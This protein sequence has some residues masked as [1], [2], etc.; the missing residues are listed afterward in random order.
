MNAFF[1]IN[2]LRRFLVLATISFWLG[3][4]TFYAGVVV[5]IG[6]RILGSHLRQGFITQEVSRWINVAGVAA[7]IVLAWNTRVLFKNSNAVL[8][9]LLGGSLMVITL[10]QIELFVLHPFLDRLL[11]AKAHR[12][13][14]GDSFD[15]LHRIYLGSATLQWGV[16]VLHVFCIAA[17]SE[18]PATVALTADTDRGSASV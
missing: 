6:M 2:T 11:D 7:I 18:A 9:Y 17:A 16:G 3:G 4:F 14:D 12:L 15:L 8:R 10:F 1:N 5:P 13:I